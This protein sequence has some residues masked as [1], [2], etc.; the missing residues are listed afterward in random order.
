M[1][2]ILRVYWADG[3]SKADACPHDKGVWYE[4]LYVSF[5]E[6]SCYC[7][8]KIKKKVAPTKEIYRRFFFFFGYQERSSLW[9][10]LGSMAYKGY[11]GVKGIHKIHPY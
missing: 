1:V 10:L 11:K 4:S 8:K 2:N 5:N 7:H 3:F 9:G 6:I